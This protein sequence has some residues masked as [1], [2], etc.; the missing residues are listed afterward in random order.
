MSCRSCQHWPAYHRVHWRRFPCH[1]LGLS[2]AGFTCVVSRSHPSGRRFPCLSI[3][4]QNCRLLTGQRLRG[5]SRC[6]WYWSFTGTVDS[7]A[8]LSLISVIWLEILG[9][10]CLSAGKLIVF[11]VPTGVICYGLIGRG[12]FWIDF[13]SLWWLWEAERSLWRGFN[14]RCWVSW[15]VL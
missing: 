2:A 12:I 11:R 5:C 7:R 6:C 10:N 4:A 9:T 8:P 13:R 14:S 3:A 1:L 15:V